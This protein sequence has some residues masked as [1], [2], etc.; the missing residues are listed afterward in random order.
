MRVEAGGAARRHAERVLDVV[1]APVV[2]GGTQVRMKASA[3]IAESDGASVTI[4]ELLRRA[5]VAM[6]AA[7]R[8]G[9]R[10]ESYDARLDQANLARL[11]MVRDLDAALIEGQFVL[12]YQPKIAI[13]TGVTIGGEALVRWMHP[14]RG[15]LYPDAFLPSVE[16]SGSMGRLTEIVLELAVDQLAK[17][18]AAGLAI[19]VAVNLSTSDLLDDDLPNRISSLLSKH[20]VPVS[21]LELEIT[22]SVLMADPGRASELLS[23]LHGLGLRMAVDDYGTG[24]CSLAYLRDFPID[25]LKIDKSFIADLQHD[26]R[27]HAIVSSTIELAHALNLSVVA[28]GVEDATALDTLR[29]FGCDS[30]QGFHF[31]RPLPADDF[32]AWVRARPHDS[33]L[34]LLTV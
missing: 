3:G 7:K 30:A 31:S 8:A 15:L 12:H 23:V 10:L 4:A 25:D 5:D 33:T 22:E 16:Q 28:E 34:P 20:S 29:A 2:V 18:D 32:A 19:T 11:G 24:Y 27:S 1:A 9:M 26:P 13:D 6:Y 21:A 17:W 14:T